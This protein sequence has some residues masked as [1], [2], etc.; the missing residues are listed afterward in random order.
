MISVSENFT[1]LAASIQNGTHSSPPINPIPSALGE[2]ESQVKIVV[3]D[4]ETR[5]R[6]LK[7][8]GGLAF[9]EHVTDEDKTVSA[10]QVSV[11]PVPDDEIERHDGT[12]DIPPVI[13]GRS[14]EQVVDALSRAGKERAGV[15]QSQSAL[16]E[17]TFAQGVAQESNEASAAR[18]EL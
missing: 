13:I 15:V 16:E 18:V 2:I 6:Q 4:F 14:K 3:N 7:H 11:L 17:E 9:S 10:P 1:E 5:L 12:G 8:D